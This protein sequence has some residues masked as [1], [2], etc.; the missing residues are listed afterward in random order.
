MIATLDHVATTTQ[1]AMVRAVNDVSDDYDRAHQSDLDGYTR[2][3]IQEHYSA[4]GLC[5]PD[6]PR[7]PNECQDR[8][9][10]RF[11]QQLE[12]YC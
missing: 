1:S 12:F 9:R 2:G 11:L 6:G 3:I 10:S 5:P 4:L 8:T 7:Q